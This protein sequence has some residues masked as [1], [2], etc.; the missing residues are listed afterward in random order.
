LRELGY[1]EGKNIK[2]YSEI[3]VDSNPEL[4]RREAGERFLSCRT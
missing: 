2:E 4:A 1:A 3:G